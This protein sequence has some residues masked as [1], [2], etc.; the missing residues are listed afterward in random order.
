MITLTDEAAAKVK[1]LIEAEGEPELA[2]RVAVALPQDAQ[3]SPV[4]ER[5]AVRGEPCL[6][7]AGKGAPGLL[8]QVR[9]A[10]V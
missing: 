2:L 7:G 1:D 6:Q 4:P 10:L 3:E 9:E 5:N 8:G